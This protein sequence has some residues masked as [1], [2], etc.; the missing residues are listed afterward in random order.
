MNHPDRRAARPAPNNHSEDFVVRSPEDGLDTAEPGH[1]E[2]CPA[3]AAPDGT[4]AEGP[5][6]TAAAAYTAVCS[7]PWPAVQR[8]GAPAGAGSLA[9]GH[10]PAMLKNRE[11]GPPRPKPRGASFAHCAT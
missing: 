1:T 2:A 5:I 4:E 8:N 7:A 3:L 6:D 11:P 10:T 9:S